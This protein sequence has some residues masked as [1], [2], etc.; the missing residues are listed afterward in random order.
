MT[1]KR[2]EDKDKDNVLNSWDDVDLILKEIAINH[3]EV[4]R[5]ESDMNEE[6]NN[7]KE[8]YNTKAV[9]HKDRIK[10]LELSI[11]K[12]VSK[13]KTSI[14]GKTKNLNFGSTGFR[15]STSISLPRAKDKK[16]VIIKHLKKESMLD[17]INVEESINKEALKKYDEDT[18]IRVGAKLK[19]SDT[20]WYEL[21]LDK[22]K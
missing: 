6:I 14:V 5:I 16:E 12:F 3:I 21:N 11:K 1:R 13:N 19:K 2:F 20:F 9:I 8:T 10:E 7:L 15:A 4:Q 17:C 22:I 18:I